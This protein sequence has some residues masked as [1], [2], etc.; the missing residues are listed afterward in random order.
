MYR[1]DHH[2]YILILGSKYPV[3][4]VFHSE[5]V[6]TACRLLVLM[7][8]VVYLGEGSHDAV[9]GNQSVLGNHQLGHIENYLY[10]YI[11]NSNSMDQ[12]DNIYKETHVT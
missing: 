5:I 7:L 11:K 4:I 3:N 9:V 6:F 2:S 1:L 12:K 10:S 8:E